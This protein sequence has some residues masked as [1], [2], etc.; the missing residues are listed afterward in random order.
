M[1]GM[2][3]RHQFVEQYGWSK[4]FVEVGHFD[5]GAYKCLTPGENNSG[6][7]H[8]HYTHQNRHRLLHFFSA[9]H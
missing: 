4:K 1:H 5:L 7:E 8:G 3:A 2:S 6:G 9:Q